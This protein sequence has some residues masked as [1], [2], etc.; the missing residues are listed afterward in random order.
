MNCN[1]IEMLKSNIHIPLCN[2]DHFIKCK[3]N[4]CN[5]MINLND[6]I[7]KNRTL[8]IKDGENPFDKWACSASCYSKYRYIDMYCDSC[9]KITKHTKANNV[10][11]S[12][13]EKSKY[14]YKWCDV[15]EA[16]TVHRKDV[17]ISCEK[18]SYVHYEWCDECKEN[19][20]RFGGSG[21]KCMKCANKNF[22]EKYCDKCG[23]ITWHKAETCMVCTSQKDYSNEWC[24]KC[25]KFTLHSQNKHICLSCSH[26]L[27]CNEEWC[28][29]CQS[30]SMHTIYGTC[31]KCNSA[32]YHNEWCDKCGKETTHTDKNNICISCASSIS[33]YESYCNECKRITQ[34]RSID[35]SCISCDRNNVVSYYTDYC[36]E[37][38]QET[39][40]LYSTNGY[41]HCM[42]CSII[43]GNENKFKNGRM[44]RS[45]IEKKIM[46]WIGAKEERI[47]SLN[48][49]GFLQI[50]NKNIV[51]EYD[52]EYYHKDSD[53]FERD[54]RNAKKLLDNGYIVI[55]MREN[56]LAHLNIH[57]N[58]LYQVNV[59]PKIINSDNGFEYIKSIMNKIGV[60]L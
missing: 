26:K 59:D 35:D 24:D 43:K 21:S 27:I 19:T 39:T 38:D 28:D 57:D 48:V 15:C 30:Y 46:G 16:N 22:N 36:Y 56:N 47:L 49:D 11:L 50:N 12:C 32:S 40:W 8:K 45:Q 25:N 18:K 17:C 7:N 55:R 13:T 1:C 9:G 6:H 53:K 23:R 54:E 3:Y 42:R 44:N 52:G 20:K 14:D 34:H 5:N 2:N 58:N 60:V 33:L 51:I 4:E 10:C 29:K 31:L 41:A 37:C